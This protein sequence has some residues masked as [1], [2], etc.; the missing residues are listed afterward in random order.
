MKLAPILC[1]YYV[2]Y[3][4]YLQH[5]FLLTHS[6][7]FHTILYSSYIISHHAFF[8]FLFPT[9]IRPTLIVAPYF[10]FPFSLQDTNM[11]FVCYVMYALHLHSTYKPACLPRLILFFFHALLFCFVLW[12]GEGDI[13]FW[14]GWMDWMTDT[15][16]ITCICSYFIFYPVSVSLTWHWVLVPFAFAALL[17]LPGVFSL[18]LFQES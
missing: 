6:I 13:L 17:C 1:Y 4:L 2:V 7:P 11:M 8:S 9:I 18:F 5:I 15:L 3:L 14:F 10:S 16:D 12:G